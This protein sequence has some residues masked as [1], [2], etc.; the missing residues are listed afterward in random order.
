[1]AY[2]DI[3]Y[4][5]IPHAYRKQSLGKIKMLEFIQK[6]SGPQMTLFY[7][8]D[9]QWYTPHCSKITLRPKTIS[10]LELNVD[11]LIVKLRDQ[12]LNAIITNTIDTDFS[13]SYLV[14]Y[15]PSEMNQNQLTTISEKILSSH[16]KNYHL[17][18]EIVYIRNG[19]TLVRNT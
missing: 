9:D 14:I 8:P 10:E 7:S 13:S 1:M 4:K 2:V 12:I 11:E 3:D 6:L 5:G 16:E 15:L 18:A 17:I 19:D